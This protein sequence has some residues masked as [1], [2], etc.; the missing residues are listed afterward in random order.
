[1]SALKDTE[2]RQGFLLRLPTEILL[3]IIKDESL[4][5]DDIRDIGL[6]SVRLYGITRKIFYHGRKLLVFR[7]ALEGGCVEIMTKCSDYDA[8]PKNIAWWWHPYEKQ[9]YL[10]DG[11]KDRGR[12]HRPVDFLLKGYRERKFSANRCIEAL[13]WL[14]DNGY[15]THQYVGNVDT[16]RF[17]IPF[18]LGEMLSAVATDKELHQGVC[19]IIHFLYSKDF[20]L[21]T[22]TG[23]KVYKSRPKALYTIYTPFSNVS[24]DTME[25]LMQSACPPSIL[26][27]YLKQ[28]DNRG[29]HLKSRL[30]KP[31]DWWDIGT[32]PTF[33]K[34]EEILEILFDDLF[35]PWT[36][37][38]E[39]PSEVGDILD[40]KIDL[41]TRYQG[42]CDD[43]RKVLNDIVAALR[44]I[45]AKHEE[46]GLTF[47]RDGVW[48]W[49]EL[50][51]SVSD[52]M[53]KKTLSL[54]DRTAQ[55]DELEEEEEPLP[56]HEFRTEEERWYPPE[57]IAHARG[58]IL[59]ARRRQGEEVGQLH[60]REDLTKAEWWDMPLHAWYS[61]RVKGDPRLKGDAEFRDLLYR[62]DPYRDNTLRFTY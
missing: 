21:G 33:T 12:F 25:V 38:A 43:E 2:D 45:E 11:N 32:S 46:R 62:D 41:L 4:E 56:L 54:R 28:L 37:K 48:C 19:S 49:Y 47:K 52:I 13:K 29:V 40:A 17:W 7:A 58:L 23:P 10:L 27:L 1:M 8:A 51:M 36:W 31:V 30:Q 55:Y 14:I 6:V 42:I 57:K 20:T 18:V 16:K 26:E 22:W 59:D 15:R 44:R 60:D 9:Y 53:S 34:V 3:M 35:D 39:Y 5:Y 61:V 24:G 50:C